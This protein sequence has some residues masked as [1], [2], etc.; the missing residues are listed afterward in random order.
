[1]KKIFS[2]LIIA[3]M[4]TTSLGACQS[5]DGISKQ[6]IGL[7]TGAIGGAWLGSNV[8]KGKGKIVGTAV[9]TMMGA[10]IGRS[11]GASLDRADQVYYGK[12]SQNTLES[13][14]TGKAVEWKNPDTGTSGTITP[15]KT[16][17]KA[18]NRYCREYTQKIDV[19][20]KSVE[21]YGTACRK[22]D[23]SWEIIK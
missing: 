2:S 9:G 5:M 18:D 23:G 14:P 19:G 6:D 4:L 10:A 22:P 15:V 7:L 11:V 12:V 16:Y 17:Q 1:M 20:G 3:G 13:A 21:G 8:G